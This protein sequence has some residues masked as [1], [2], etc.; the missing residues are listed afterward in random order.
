MPRIIAEDFT[1]VTNDARDFRRLYSK[2][3]LHA[4]LIIL[5]PQLRAEQQ[6]LLF[7]AALRELRADEQ[8]PVNE[9]IEVRFDQGEAIIDRYPLPR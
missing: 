3:V 1:F 6:L 2:T 5:I 8:P 4:G 7:D 9:V